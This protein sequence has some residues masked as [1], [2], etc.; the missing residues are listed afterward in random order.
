MVSRKNGI[1]VKGTRVDRKLKTTRKGP[2]EGNG[3]GFIT[4]SIDSEFPDLDFSFSNFDV[5]KIKV[6]P[7]NTR[8]DNN[9][10]FPLKKLNEKSVYRNWKNYDRNH[11]QSQDLE[12]H[13]QLNTKHV[14]QSGYVYQKPTFRPPIQSSTWGTAGQK[15]PSYLMDKSPSHLYHY[16]KNH[17]Y[18]SYKYDPKYDVKSQRIENELDVNKINSGF[19]FLFYNKNVPIQYNVKLSN[20]FESQKFGTLYREEVI[21]PINKQHKTDNQLATRQNNYHQQTIT[22]KQPRAMTTL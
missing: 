14:Q 11:K 6:N 10:M 4:E 2:T 1:N 19:G 7:L 3:R 21:G 15:I 9:Y 12:K 20:N 18:H 8:R 16:Q 22:N 5:P 13:M 17:H